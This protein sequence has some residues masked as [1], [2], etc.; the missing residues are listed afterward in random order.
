MTSVKRAIYRSF[1]YLRIAVSLV[2]FPF[3]FLTFLT[4]FYQYVNFISIELFIL[5]SVTVALICLPLFGYYWRKYSGFY[6]AEREVDISFDP[7]TTTKIAP[8]TIALWQPM[9]VFLERNGVD[10][11][12]I[13]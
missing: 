1:Y 10:C 6:K 5:V 4:V 3:T 9:A 7:F 13:K 8:T 2:S 12:T 11:T